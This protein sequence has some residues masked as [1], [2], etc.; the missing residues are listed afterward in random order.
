[1]NG[2]GLIPKILELGQDEIG[3]IGEFFQRGEGALLVE[4]LTGGK[5]GFGLRDS[6]HGI[7]GREGFEALGADL[8][9]AIFEGFVEKGAQAV[10]F[11]LQKSFESG[12]TNGRG[13]LRIGE[14]G[15]QGRRCDL[16]AKPFGGADDL[17]EKRSGT[18]VEEE[19]QGLGE[20]GTKLC[21]RAFIG[22]RAV[23]AGGGIGGG[24]VFPAL[25]N[26]EGFH[27]DGFRVVG[28]CRDAQRTAG[29]FLIAHAVDG[30]ENSVVDH[31]A[32]LAE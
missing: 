1:M 17:G 18:G 16:D 8:A 5:D 10:F 12:E 26:E 32:G 20:I 22:E 23:L 31:G 13:V 6:G 9:V 27:A 14:V 21:E 24:W 25:Q 7:E 28:I 11:V 19:V 15:E 2:G 3:G 4:D 30:I 29:I